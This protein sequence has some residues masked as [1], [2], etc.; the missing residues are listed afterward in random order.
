[1][2]GWLLV[3]EEVFRKKENIPGQTQ[4]VPRMFLIQSSFSIL[5]RMVLNSLKA[6]ST[7]SETG[8]A[9]FIQPCVV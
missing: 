6:A 7:Q 5:S 3:E 2:D 8:F 4:K 1:M 9:G